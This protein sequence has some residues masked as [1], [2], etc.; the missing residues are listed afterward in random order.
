MLPPGIQVC[1]VQL[2]GREN[3]L[4]EPPLNRLPHIV[5]NVARA[6]SPY[7]D[8]PFVF[9]GHS[10]GALISIELARAL[11]KT[12]API[13][14][15]LAVAAYRAPHLLPVNPPIHHLPDPVFLDELSRRYDGIPAAIA[16]NPELR[17][18]FLPLLKAD[19]AVIETYTHLS[20]PPLEC[21]MSAFGGL[22]DPQVSHADL[23]A[24]SIH[25]SSKFKL[26]MLPGRH[27]FLNVS[28]T[29]L[30]QALAEDIAELAAC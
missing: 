14:R 20:V 22:Q 29:L 30:L 21:P 27:F 24:W 8:V 9:F 6:L 16:E 5:E 25:T 10:M 18:L 19:L 17:E 12:G 1:P 13:P 11:R 4:S 7:L 26:R 23:A 28:R 15:L 2:P 3:R